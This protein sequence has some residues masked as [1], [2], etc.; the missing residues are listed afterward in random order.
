MNMAKKRSSG[1]FFLV[2]GVILAYFSVFSY[3]L[4][5]SL[6]AWWF[7]EV[8]PVL[9]TTRTAFLN[10]FGFVGETGEELELILGTLGI[11]GIV[12]FLVGPLLSILS[13]LK[14]SK[15]LA[16]LG[17]FLMIS[18]LAIFLYGLANVQDYESILEDLSFLTGDE[19]LVYFGTVD[20]GLL[21]IWT[22]MLGVG[23]YIATVGTIVTLI[24]AIKL[25]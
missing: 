21:G 19:Y 15:I 17:F 24:G 9:G 14:E 16:Y 18:A 3:F 2:I 13:I 4:L 11:F 8:D 1:K 22:W 20:L 10:A 5:D 7:V 23:F 12:L 6:G 25:N